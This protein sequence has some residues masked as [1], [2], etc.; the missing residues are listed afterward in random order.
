VKVRVVACLPAAECPVEVVERLVA[1]VV[2][3]ADP[4]VEALVAALRV[5]AVDSRC[6][7]NKKCG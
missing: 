7:R 2:E 5:V 1:A 3:W 6:P 4:A